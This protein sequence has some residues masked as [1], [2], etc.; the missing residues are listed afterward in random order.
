MEC[1]MVVDWQRYE[2][3]G[4]LLGAQNV[5]FEKKRKKEKLKNLFKFSYINE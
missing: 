2:D 3:R 4:F 5:P 1:V